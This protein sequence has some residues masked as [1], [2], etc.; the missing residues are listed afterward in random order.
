M[1]F[2]SYT[3]LIPAFN[4]QNTIVLLLD[5]LHKIDNPPTNIYVID[6][7]S[8]DN[9]TALAEKCNASVFRFDINQGKGAALQKGFELF[10]KQTND[11]FLICM[12]ADLQHAPSAIKS[13]LKKAISSSL[14]FSSLIF[15]A[16]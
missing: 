7:G 12:D 15:A 2:P 10:E 6:D 8:S 1:E 9:T 14:V 3:V 5:Q 13:F 16:Y 4:A 11:D